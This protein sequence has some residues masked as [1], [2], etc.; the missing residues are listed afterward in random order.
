MGALKKH[1]ATREAATTLAGL[2]AQ[3]DAFVTY[4]NNI[5][6]H[7][8]L[9]RRTPRAAYAGRP[10]A[11]PIGSPAGR[12]HRVRTDRIDGQGKVTLRYSGHLYKIGVGRTHAP[13]PS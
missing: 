7:R 2:Q 3:L 10:K 13:T 9:G 5:R 4:D 6:P 1:L 8:S 12:D 11:V